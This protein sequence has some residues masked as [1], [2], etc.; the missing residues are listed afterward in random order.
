MFGLTPSAAGAQNF[1]VSIDGSAPAPA[2]YSDPNPPSYREWY[3]SPLLSEG[4]HNLFLS[5]VAGASI[6]FVTVTVGENTALANQLVIADN[7]DAGFSYN[8]KWRESTA[9][10]NSGP[11]PDGNPYH[12]STH[13]TNY[14]G[15]TFTYKFTGECLFRYSHM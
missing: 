8:G 9:Q 14:I 3:Q 7:D 12:N 5:Q 6:D 10:F 13:Q 1:M 2:T 11:R 4:T 15:D